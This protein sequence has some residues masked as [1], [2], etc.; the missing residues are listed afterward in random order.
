MLREE[1]G[2]ELP[3]PRGLLSYQCAREEDPATN[4]NEPANSGR[5]RIRL[6]GTTMQGPPSKAALVEC[7][8][9]AVQHGL[10]LCLVLEKVPDASSGTVAR[11]N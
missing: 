2:P 3:K 9:F 1:A 6:E 11:A 10:A 4:S 5:V 8:G 7:Y